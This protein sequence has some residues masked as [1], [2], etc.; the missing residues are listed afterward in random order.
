MPVKSQPVRNPVIHVGRGR[1]VLRRGAVGRGLREA[2]A[3][4]GRGTPRSG[5]GSSGVSSSSVVVA[6]GRA[7]CPWSSRGSPEPELSLASSLLAHLVPVL[8]LSDPGSV[9]TTEVA[10]QASGR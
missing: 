1:K 9:Q 3:G 10:R 8:D 6:L 5:F 2:A 4:R 7:K